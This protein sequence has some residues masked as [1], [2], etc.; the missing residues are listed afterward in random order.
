MGGQQLLNL[1]LNGLLE[2]LS[3]TSAQQFGQQ[4]GTPYSTFQ[5]NNV[6]LSHGGVSLWLIG[7]LAIT[8]QPDTSPFFKPSNTTFGYNSPER[9]QTLT[10]QS[11]RL[12]QLHL[13]VEHRRQLVADK[14]RLTN[15]LCA[16]LK[17]YYP[18]SLEWFEKLDTV[19]F[20]E[21][22]K[23]WPTLRK[24]QSARSTTLVRFFNEN[25]MYRQ[26]VQQRRLDGIRKAM[27]LTLE[28]AL[29]EPFSLKAQ[30]IAEQLRLVLAAIQQ[31]GQKIS[32]LASEHPDYELFVSLPG[33]GA[34][35][36]PRLLVAF[37]EERER[38]Q[39]AGEL[40]MYTGIAPV[41]ERSGQ[42]CWVHWRTQCPRFLRQTIV[43]WAGHS[44]RYSFWAE[45][46]YRQQR[47][48]GSNHQAAVR[49]LAFK[50]LRILYRCWQ[51]RTQYDESKYLKAL[52]QR[53]S[54]LVAA[55]A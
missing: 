12:R 19:L 16:A 23:Q 24:A 50:W 35:L 53:G 32:E 9:F 13:L 20:C 40:Q 4:I 43:E 6:T 11:A 45:A 54:P 14:V 31:Y 3:G 51:T 36:A 42:K 27:P 46:F 25:H 5:L 52:Q 18:Q 22:I 29:I 39:S 21:F 41:T 10:A 48:K 8:N 47:N 37:G 44:I 15:R 30:L 1:G 34:S 38:F 17:Q 49:A 33:A 7:C 55:A 26:S 2:E 28:E